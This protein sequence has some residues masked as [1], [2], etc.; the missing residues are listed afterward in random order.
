MKRLIPFLSVLSVILAG[1][2]STDLSEVSIQ[3]MILE[4]SCYNADGPV[5]AINPGFVYKGFIEVTDLQGEIIERPDHRNLVVYSENK[6]FVPGQQ[7][8]RKI[9][10]FPTAD[11]F[12]LLK[13]GLYSLTLGI[14]DNPYPFQTYEWPVDWSGFSYIDYRGNDGEDGD[15]G[16]DGRDARGKSGND[17]DGGDGYMGESGENGMRG[18]DAILYAFFYDVSDIRVEGL[19]T[20]RMILFVDS[21]DGSAYLAPLYHVTID[22]TGG[23]GGS[24]G[25]GGEGGDGAYYDGDDFSATGVQGEG[26]PGGFGGDGG[27]GGTIAVY[28]TDPVILE[29]INPVIDGGP[30]GDGG[31]T[32]YGNNT[33]YNDGFPGEEGEPGLYYTSP[34]D[35][36]DIESVLD[37]VLNPN[38]ERERVILK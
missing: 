29:Y 25:D 37:M 36:G 8:R 20:D 5:D 31:D 33:F 34:A 21:M 26:G 2:S 1:C 32:G 27:G 24:G 18:R 7:T 23:A 6:T 10:L 9:V 16:R 15:D 14:A 35:P 19:F 30:G 3:D 12:S 13:T 11:A 38:F 17:I 22:S 28:Y 4:L